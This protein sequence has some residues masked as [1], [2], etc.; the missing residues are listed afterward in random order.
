MVDI[1]IHQSYEEVVMIIINT[2]AAIIIIII[3]FNKF[4]NFISKDILVSKLD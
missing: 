2:A 3:F 1:Q 4:K